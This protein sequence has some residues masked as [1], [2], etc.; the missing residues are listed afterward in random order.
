M[1]EHE[2]APHPLAGENSGFEHINRLTEL[3]NQAIA[4]GLIIGHG[5]HEGQYEILRRGEVLLF[6]PE[7][8]QHHLETW[9]AQAQE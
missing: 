8:A 6:S 7:D 4:A 2:D 3:G 9:L 5:Y 1:S